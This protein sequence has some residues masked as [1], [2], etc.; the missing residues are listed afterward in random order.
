[1]SSD[2]TGTTVLVR[3]ALRRDRLLIPLWIGLSAVDGLVLR[4]RDR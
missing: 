4:L 3:L 2:L 1:V